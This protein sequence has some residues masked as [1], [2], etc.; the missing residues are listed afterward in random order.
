MKYVYGFLAGISAILAIL[1]YMLMVATFIIFVVL[2]VTKIMGIYNASWWW[3]FLWPVITGVGGFIIMAISGLMAGVFAVAT[4][5]E[6]KKNRR[7]K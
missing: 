5:E 3:V 1:A 2:F 4:D 7:L 6:I